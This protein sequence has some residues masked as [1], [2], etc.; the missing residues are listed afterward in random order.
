MEQLASLGQEP[1]DKSAGD[2][3]QKGEKLIIQNAQD[4]N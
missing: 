3:F 1:A 4:K 2:I